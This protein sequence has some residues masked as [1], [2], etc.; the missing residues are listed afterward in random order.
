MDSKHRHDMLAALRF[1]QNL[2]EEIL[3]ASSL[4]EIKDP[5]ILQKF[6]ESITILN[7]FCK[8]QIELDPESKKND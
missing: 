3:V 5:S 8:E 7:G 1:L 2:Y 6:S 4:E